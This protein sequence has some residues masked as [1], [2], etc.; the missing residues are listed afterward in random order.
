[1][2]AEI[3]QAQILVKTA[4]NPAVYSIAN[5]KKH[6]IPNEKTFL[7]YGY[8]WNGIKTI[9]K[10]ELNSYPDARIVKTKN[11]PTV[12]YLDLSKKLKKA[13]PSAKVFLDY[14][15]KWED[16]LVISDIDLE[17]YN[18]ANLVK[19]KKSPAIYVLNKNTR[20]LVS[21]PEEFENA[22]YKWPDIIEVSRLDLESYALSTQGISAANLSANDPVQAETKKTPILNVSLVKDDTGKVVPTGSVGEFLKILLYSENGETVI[23]GFDITAFGV[24]TDKDVSYVHLLDENDPA[25]RYKTTINNKSGHIGFSDAPLVISEGESR[26]LTIEAG[27]NENPDASFRTIGFGIKNASGIR[28]SSEVSG[29]FPLYGIEKQ[30]QNI[31]NVIG[32]INISPIALIN[33]VLEINQGAKDQ[34]V[35]KFN[36]SETSG[37][38]DIIL[39]EISFLGRGNIKYSDLL[40]FDLVDDNGKVLQTQ[41][42]MNKDMT[43]SFNLDK[44]P[45]KIKKKTT[46]TI[47]LKADIL[48]KGEKE[49]NFLF[50]DGRARGLST[51]IELLFSEKCFPKN[52]EKN[53]NK[54]AIK[55]GA[56]TAFTD[57]SSPKEIIAGKENSL[58]GVF[59][60]SALNTDV[61]W[62]EARV[63][64][65]YSGAPLEN[66]LIF[67]DTATKKEFLRIG[68]DVLSR[69]KSILISPYKLIKY[70]TYL[71][72]EIRTDIPERAS[73]NDTYKITLSNFSFK[74]ANNYYGTVFETMESNMLSVRASALYI[75][76]NKIDDKYVAGSA[77]V[78]LGSFTLQANYAEDIYV[79]SITIK[80]EEGYSEVSAA[81]GFYNFNINLMKNEK[82]QPIG[83][84]ITI[85]LKSPRIIPAGSYFTMD[86]YADTNPTAAGRIFKLEAVD[87]SAY[88]AASKI[89][90]KVEGLGARSNQV[91]L[92]KLGFEA[93]ANPEFIPDTTG[94]GKSI[95]IGSFKLTSDAD[96]IRITELT[97]ST[98]ASSDTISY[99]NGYTRLTLASGKKVLAR[100]EKPLP[101]FNIFK[102]SFTVEKGK[103]MIVD[104]YVDIPEC[105]DCPERNLQVSINSLKGYGEKSNVIPIIDSAI[106]SNPVKI[107]CDCAN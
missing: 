105:C 104:V 65:A 79:K 77:N 80:S 1:F 23:N 78:K 76:A 5:G 42:W 40:N 52:E 61:A 25:F 39:T 107:L 15:N 22:G 32:K 90:P 38:E 31:G 53:T 51:S 101:E 4:E 85:T 58:L 48:V 46:R 57:S 20:K 83:I 75:T 91:E 24:M 55:N 17:N 16:I 49:F 21:S 60:L 82:N 70:K 13:H 47:T 102:P 19:E 106:V 72:F 94:C 92:V 69:E 41:V 84:P 14:G 97:L 95:K 27:I 59:Q 36:I 6:I 26:T 44:N 89:K 99:Q 33:N 30:M 28:T 12:Y 93:A 98:S 86:I 88:G 100:I 67:I 3:T 9:S 10:N 18:E 7:S 96:K 35:A 62:Q 2:A 66:D 37:N 87:I 29:Q 34:T 8:K 73:S 45:L 56:L 50:N 68:G 103:D 81:T 74:D 11:D 71:K 54:L 63:N 64:L 43:V